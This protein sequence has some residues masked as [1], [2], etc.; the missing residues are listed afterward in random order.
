M[1]F[2]TRVGGLILGLG[3][4]V[5][6]A[7]ALGPEGRGAYALVL[8][9]FGLLQMA[10]ALGLDQASTF[11]SA[12]SPS[13]AGKITRTLGTATL[14]LGVLVVAVYAALSTHPAYRAFL[15]E[16]AVQPEMVWILVLLLPASMLNQL[17][18]GVLLGLER[19]G[20]FNLGGLVT[21][22]VNLAVLALF[23][24]L[25]SLRLEGALWAAGA[26][27]LAGTLASGLLLLRGRLRPGGKGE[28]E[29]AGGVPATGPQ[30]RPGG[31]RREESPLREGLAFGWKAQVGALSWFLHYRS[32]MILVS[33]LSGPAALGYYAVAVGLVE[34]LYL[35]PSAIGTVLFPRL[36]REGEAG[37][38]VLTPLASRITLL[39]TLSATV[40]LAA[41]SWPLIRVL[42]GRA[43][44]PALKPLLI[45]LPGVAA[46]S[47][48]RVLSADLNARGKPGVVAG[49][50][51][52]LA[53]V[54]IGLNL[55]WIPILGVSGAALA[56][57][58]SY[59]L[60]VLILAWVF[61]RLAGARYRDV[62]IP[63][64]EDAARVLAGGRELRRGWFG[65][66]EGAS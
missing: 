38:R 42:F 13:S 5:I 31:D 19:V 3:I 4:G 39:L 56:T 37:R 17:F 24:L 18:L 36:A 59:T 58:T 10:G 14:I 53:L 54:N 65:R 49:V 51:L 15:A 60:A 23:S 63:S 62:L 44:L 61:V 57:T 25:F 40:P 35:L 43:F 6:V 12:R 27:I 32:D 22:G 41:L 52:L 29:E 8:V 20:S 50:N 45:L 30:G 28:P 11:L 55:W 47:V 34:K 1:T 64:R 33:A 26:G 48:G 21:S 16:S 66:R 46:L 9:V 7:R 2:A